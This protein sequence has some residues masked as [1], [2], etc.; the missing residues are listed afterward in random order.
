MSHGNIIND[1][2]KKCARTA[3]NIGYVD[4]NNSS[5]PEEEWNHKFEI[6]NYIFFFEI[7]CCNKIK[8]NF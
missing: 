7:F 3:Q 8:K 5:P 6:L 1:I 2:S 4:P